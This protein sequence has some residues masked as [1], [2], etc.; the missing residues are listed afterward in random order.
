MPSPLNTLTVCCCSVVPCSFPELPVLVSYY[1][2][3]S[4][5]DV[6][7]RF[8]SILKLNY[9][10]VFTFLR[11]HAHLVTTSAALSENS[12]Y[13]SVEQQHTSR[14][15]WWGRKSVSRSSGATVFATR[16]M[17][18]SMSSK[19]SKTAMRQTVSRGEVA[20]QVGSLRLR[21]S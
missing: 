19:T 15:S 7:R 12:D 17:V 9:V 3:A 5:I 16:W 2:Y 18:L 8:H 21:R 10:L 20:R 13:S 14:E 11:M 4:R 6:H 1:E